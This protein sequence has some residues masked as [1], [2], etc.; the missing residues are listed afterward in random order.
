[1]VYGHDWKWFQIPRLVHI[2]VCG[3]IPQ[4]SDP[5][6][7]MLASPRYTRETMN[8]Q[9]ARIRLQNMGRATFTRE[10]CHILPADCEVQKICD[11][12]IGVPS[13]GKKSSK[14]PTGSYCSYWCYPSFLFLWVIPVTV[15]KRNDQ[16]LW[17]ESKVLSIISRSLVSS[18]PLPSP[19]SRVIWSQMQPNITVQC[20]PPAVISWWISHLTLVVFATLAIN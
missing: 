4:M 15:W 20:G 5:M 19:I 10:P 18:S 12:R 11:G 7:S 16:N 2:T 6:S 8:W 13:G 14:T 17:C 9:R 1:M 3:S